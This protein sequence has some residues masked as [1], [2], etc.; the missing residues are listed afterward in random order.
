MTIASG[1]WWI[2]DSG[3]AQY[4]DGDVGDANHIYL[5]FLTILSEWDIDVE[6]PQVPEM[7]PMEGISAEATQYLKSRNVNPEVI[8]ML[9]RGDDPREYM[10]EHKG[11]IRLAGTAAELWK[12]DDATLGTLRSGIWEA[13]GGDEWEETDLEE[14][15]FDVLVEEASTR[16]TFAIPL[17]A[18]ADDRMDAKSL[19]RLGAEGEVVEAPS[20]PA[21]R[22]AWG[23]K[24]ARERGLA[25]NP[26]RIPKSL[27]GLA[28]EAMKYDTFE[29]F[30]Q[31]FLGEIRHGTYW[32]FT[33]NPNFRIDPRRGPT[34][35]S[36]M[37]VGQQQ[38]KGKLMVTSHFDAWAGYGNRKYVALIDMSE[39]PTDAYWQVNRGFGNEFFVDDPSC[40]RVVGVYPVSKAREIDRRR[41]AALPQNAEELHQFYQIARE[42]GLEE[43]PRPLYGYHV[44]P[45]RFLPLVKQ[46]GLLSPSPQP[47]EQP[48]E[49]HF[50]DNP[51]DALEMAQPC[52]AIL[53][54][55]FPKDAS[56]CDDHWTTSIRIPWSKISIVYEK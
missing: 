6:D 33:S 17:K 5:A 40:A 13:W 3:M 12:F 11:W 47:E 22:A 50:H 16:R 2:D 31:A 10:I 32:H 1:E 56:P 24:A 48:D 19:K 51:D 25:E 36:T 15:D 14:L 7:L 44:I 28:A 55:K 34:D 38:D 53:R 39:V 45:K 41:H 26:G 30:E 52:D 49:T 21:L 42:R 4:A 46:H 29:D 37:S 43:N 35:R 27:Q 23:R 20:A 8:A 18:L 9:G 54:F